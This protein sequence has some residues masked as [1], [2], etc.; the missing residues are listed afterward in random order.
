MN[1]SFLWIVHIVSLF[2]NRYRILLSKLLLY[3]V[4]QLS[5]NDIFSNLFKF[6]CILNLLLFIVFI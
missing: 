3:Y 5:E 4:Y 1:I 2:Y 6:Y